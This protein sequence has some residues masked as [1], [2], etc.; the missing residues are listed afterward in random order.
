M[1][2][3]KLLNCTLLYTT[4]L[5]SHTCLAAA[6]VYLPV[7]VSPAIESDIDR[8][9]VLAN[10]PKLTKPYSATMLQQQLASI[11]NS[12]PALYKRLHKVFAH[13][14]QPRNITH[15]KATLSATDD[16]LVRANAQGRSTGET[17]AASVRGFAQPAS[18]LAITVGT[19]LSEDIQQAT[20]S[21]VS[22]GTN[23]AQLDIGYKEYWLSPFQGAAQLLS[24]QA[25]TLPSISVSNY[26]PI[27][28]FDVGLGYEL[29]VAQL[30]RQPTLYRN[31]FSQ[32][33][34]PLLAGLAV[35]LR[36]TPWWMLGATRLFQFGGGERPVSATT[37]A[38]AFYD[39]RGIDNDAP[40]DEESGNQVA[41]VS[42]RINFDSSI[43]FAFSV[44]LAGEDTSNNNN[45]QLGNPALTAGLYFPYFFGPSISF[46]YEYSS[47]DSAWY[48]N[49]VYAQGYSNEDVVLG[50]WAMQDQHIGKTAAPAKS[51][52]I[53]T[54]WLTPWQHTLDL[55]LRWA[56]H[57]HKK[58]SHAWS[59]DADYAVPTRWGNVALG[60]LVGQNSFDLNYVQLR[61]SAQWR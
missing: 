42:S 25:Q 51:Q 5:A 17:A 29:F 8:L 19:E 47:W 7:N 1:D 23:W 3:K 30:S 22:L 15:A 9:V 10:I 60:A 50:T 46:T 34:N 28:V 40:V 58:Y 43:P 59:A 61:V 55:S 52:F 27:N 41:A 49:N 45:I 36:P 20:G 33:N 37:L 4:C 16:N 54:Q 53:K 39:P 24:T 18:W 48:V 21:M 31:T 38:R 13:Y 6:S 32:K 26:L 14:A 57:D 56:E 44:E 12:H 35:T 11:E 2:T